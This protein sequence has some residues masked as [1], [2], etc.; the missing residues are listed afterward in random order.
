MPRCQ[1][2]LGPLM[3]PVQRSCSLRMTIAVI[4]LAEASLASL[5]SN[6][7]CT[8][9]SE[10]AAIRDGLG[11]SRSCRRR[12]R[13]RSWNSV[14]AVQ[15]PSP[16]ISPILSISAHF[17]SSEVTARYLKTRAQ[18][19]PLE[20]SSHG[21]GAATGI[22]NHDELEPDPGSRGGPSP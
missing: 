6:S 22:V 21:P 8:T 9:S 19:S 17:S 20:Q 10:S 14:R 5:H 13:G 16:I 15:D 18:A 4:G 7:S 11:P 1:S 12:D 3:I 2:W